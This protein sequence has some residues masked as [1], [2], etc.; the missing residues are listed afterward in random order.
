MTEQPVDYRPMWTELGLDLEKHDALLAVLGQ[1]YQDVYLSQENRPEGMGYFDFVMSEVHGLRIQELMNA[2]KEGRIV[3]GSFCVFV[4][5]EL[6][7]AVDG[8]SVGLCAGAGIRPGGRRTLRA[9]QHLLAYQ[10]R[11]RLRRREGLPLPRGIRRGGWR[12]HL[13]WQEKEL[14][15]LCRPCERLLRHGPAS[16]EKRG[17]ARSSQGR[18]HPFR[19]AAGGTLGT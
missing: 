8:V 10:I 1:A 4:P 7:L 6:I 15:S 14:R 19:E 16:G 2:K 5:E 17:R 11:F 12:K 18:I 13:R 9:A 3:V